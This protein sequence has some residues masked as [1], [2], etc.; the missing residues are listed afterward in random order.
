LNIKNVIKGV[1]SL[2]LSAMVG[3]WVFVAMEGARLFF[4]A[5]L[6]ST[7][8]VGNLVALEIGVGVLTGAGTFIFLCYLR[9]IERRATRTYVD[10]EPPPGETK[11]KNPSSRTRRSF[12]SGRLCYTSTWR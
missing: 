6:L 12:R 7:E 8:R 10:P 1:G 11:D 3:S 9:Y 2:L 4:S 5:D